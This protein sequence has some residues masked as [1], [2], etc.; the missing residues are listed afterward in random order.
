[1]WI[2]RLKGDAYERD[3]RKLRERKRVVKRGKE[4]IG[5]MGGVRSMNDREGGFL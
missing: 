2:S 4:A 5:S 1:L 3:E